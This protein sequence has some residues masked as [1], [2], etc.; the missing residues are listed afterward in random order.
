MAKFSYKRKILKLPIR[1]TV[2][3]LFLILSVLIMLIM[4]YIQSMIGKDLARSTMNDY[5]KI[6]SNKVEHNIDS[7]NIKSNILVHSNASYLKN[8]TFKDFYKNEKK[9]FQHFIR[10]LE[11][12]EG[13][14][15]M[16][17]GFKNNRFYEIIKLDIDDKL[18]KKYN[19]T[20]DDKWL[21][22]EIDTELNQKLSLFDRNLKRT[23]LKILKTDYRVSQRP[24]YKSAL[25][26][27]QI[28]KIGPYDFS[29]IHSK[30]LTYSLN[31]G[32][33]NI[34]AIDVLHNDF[35]KILNTQNIIKTLESFV[36]TE[37]FDSLVS[38]KNKD[39]VHVEILKEL[40]NQDLSQKIENIK[41]INGKEYLYTV[42]LLNTNYTLKEYLVSYVLLDEMIAPF[43]KKFQKIDKIMLVL[44]FIL[45]P[46]IWYFA[47]IIVK[48]ILLLA[49]VSKKVKHRKFDQI[50]PIDGFVYEI[51]LLS[52]A[53]GSMAKSIDV[54]QTDLEKIVEQRTK[55]LENKNKAL[56]VLSVTDKLTGIYN[57]IMLD[58][59][60]D[61]E[62]SKSK[63]SQ[64]KFGIVLIDIDYFKDVNDTYGHQVG[65]TTLVTFAN[66]LKEHIR[67]VDLL[68]RWGGEE[69]VIVCG[70]SSLDAILSLSEKLRILVEEYDFPVIHTK[71]ASFGVSSYTQN[72]TAESIIKRAD[73]ALYK[74]KEEGRNKVETLDLNKN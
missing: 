71:T 36:F 67:D 43:M 70:D 20:Q 62:I 21:L 32:N 8:I 16:Y 17:I 33:D 4:L 26:K 49:K 53:I 66:I 46:I 18:R 73:E 45:L 9:Y 12:T 1:I 64:I 15:S 37:N 14:Y 38:V 10:Q 74:A 34:F 7:V 50:V 22:V 44:F 25:K 41:L 69:F 72:D 23:S 51:D 28:T 5:F 6:I 47:S 29:N 68:G 3:G 56:E 54:Y 65:D 42:S 58:K 2:T 31:L 55:E 11:N 24:W 48:P 19:A 59:T 13:F 30:G 27:N 60:I 39:L 52:K 63:T 57:R 40:K 35:T 61:E